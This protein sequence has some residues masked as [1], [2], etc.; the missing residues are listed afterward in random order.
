MQT[1]MYLGNSLNDLMTLLSPISVVTSWLKGKEV[2][3]VSN[4]MHVHWELMF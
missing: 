2:F 1:K 4:N 3:L